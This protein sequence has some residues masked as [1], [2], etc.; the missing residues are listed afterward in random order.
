MVRSE[1]V[2]SGNRWGEN[3]KNP[4][5]GSETDDFRDADFWGVG[6]GF[7]NPSAFIVSNRDGN[8]GIIRS[9]VSAIVLLDRDRL[10][11][12]GVADARNRRS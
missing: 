2:D 3:H 12:N 6:N 9:P 8:A 11:Q 4:V 1:T 7:V 10:A 5:G